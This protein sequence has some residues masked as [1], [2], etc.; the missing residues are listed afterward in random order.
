M[1]TVLGALLVMTTGSGTGAGV[2][3][4]LGGSAEAR[5]IIVERGARRGAAARRPAWRWATTL[6]FILRAIS[7]LGTWVER[8]GWECV[9]CMC[10]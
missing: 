7:V 6:M 1:E 5:T 9:M 8:V 10:V 4:V 2:G 3:G